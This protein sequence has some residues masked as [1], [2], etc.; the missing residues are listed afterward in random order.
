MSDRTFTAGEAAVIT[1][2][3]QNTAAD[4]RR[5]GLLPAGD[6]KWTRLGFRDLARLRMTRALL[7]IG[8]PVSQAIELAIDFQDSLASSVI[9]AGKPEYD[10]MLAVIAKQEI[11]I[12]R[13]V[14]FD[15]ADLSQFQR[16]EK[17]GKAAFDF[18]SIIIVNLAELGSEM[19]DKVSSLAGPAS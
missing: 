9:A 13:S 11:G 10:R 17:G 19:A 14:I 3:S 4:W 8:L 7:E 18:S 1:G 2:V 16:S 5:R 12:W 6:G 15:L